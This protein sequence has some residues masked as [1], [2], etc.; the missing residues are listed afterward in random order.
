VTIVTIM[1]PG[2]ASAEGGATGLG[3][4]CQAPVFATGLAGAVIDGRT[5]A[6]QDGREV[7][8]AGIE[9][10]PADRQTIDDG[11]FAAPAQLYLQ[12]LLDGRA[13]A[14][15]GAGPE[16]DRYG[17]LSAQVYALGESPER[18]LQAEMLAAG[19][20]RVSARVGERA[21]AGELLR[22]ERVARDAKLG[23]WS[24]PS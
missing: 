4:S 6:L 14:L 9:S 23:L 12:S 22:Y 7:R 15:K 1:S 16:R 3:A 17:R 18:W 20:A 21:C 11:A 2:L 24:D 5:F 8:L 19:Q 13:L 10:P